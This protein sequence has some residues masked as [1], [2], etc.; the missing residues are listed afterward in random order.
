MPRLVG[1][2]AIAL[3]VM[4][5]SSGSTETAQPEPEPEPP[6]VSTDGSCPTEAE[7]DGAPAVEAELLHEV[8]NYVLGGTGG[9]EL[10]TAVITDPAAYE[11]LLPGAGDSVDFGT[12]QVLMAAAVNWN[13]CYTHFHPKSWEVVEIDGAP[14]LQALWST[15]QLDC[16][17]SASCAMVGSTA[18]FV[19]VPASS[20]DATACARYEK[21][22]G[23]PCQPQ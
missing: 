8:D 6:T 16:C 12:H 9:P 23:I 4:G 11:S 18:I 1:A 21:G 15:Y 7:L 3:W 13:T 22:C 19:R 5:C 10:L 2:A 14:H 20:S 17:T